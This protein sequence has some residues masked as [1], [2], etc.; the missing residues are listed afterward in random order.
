MGVLGTGNNGVSQLVIKSQRSK[1][2]CRWRWLTFPQRDVNTTVVMGKP[3][4]AVGELEL[5]HRSRTYTSF[6]VFVPNG[7]SF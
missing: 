7:A 3:E 4:C 6:P 2:N 5:L 1:I